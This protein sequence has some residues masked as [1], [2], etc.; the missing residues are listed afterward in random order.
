M[1]VIVAAHTHTPVCGQQT[2]EEEQKCIFQE[3]E[4]SNR[5]TDNRCCRTLA[6]NTE[7]GCEFYSK[8]KNCRIEEKKKR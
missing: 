2:G 3:T 6:E 7:C 5:G 4:I 8:G 1:L